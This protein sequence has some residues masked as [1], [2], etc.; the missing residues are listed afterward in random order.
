MSIRSLEAGEA[1]RVVVVG[2]G[3]AGLTAA[4][5]LNQAGYHVTVLE[6][7]DRV[8]GRVRSLTLEN[9]AVAELGGEWIESD[10][11]FVSDLASELGVSMSPV[12]VDFAH[13][14]LIGQPS[15]PIPEHRRVAEA[16]SNATESSMTSERHEGTAASCDRPLSMC[17][18]RDRTCHPNLTLNWSV[19]SSSGP[20]GEYGG[21]SKNRHGKRFGRRPSRDGL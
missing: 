10:Q 9:G 20:R 16:V 15:I 5:R 4:Y 3:L 2:A 12:G 11:Q 19:K 17:R 6:A 14:D 1:P 18:I 7:Q 21:S 13:R 8:G